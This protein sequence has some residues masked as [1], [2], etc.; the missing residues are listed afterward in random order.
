[1]TGDPLQEARAQDARIAELEAELASER[2]SNARA[3]MV[4]LG[5]LNTAASKLIAMQD[6]KEDA[7]SYAHECRRHQIYAEQ[8]IEML[9][10]KNDKLKANLAASFAE[11]RR[12]LADVRVWKRNAMESRKRAEQLE[13]RVRELEA[14]HDLYHRPVHR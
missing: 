6:R 14:N 13:E 9:R 5:E 2:M 8:R 10:A 12:L 3:M 11:P 1:M 4:V 7:V